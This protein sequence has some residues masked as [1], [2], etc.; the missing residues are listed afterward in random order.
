MSTTA[1]SFAGLF[2]DAALFPPGNADM[3][4]AVEA[5]LARRPTDVGAVV[6]TF[7]CPASRLDELAAH[8]PPG[9][10]IDVAVVS[11][12]ATSAVPDGIRVVAVESRDPA[13][14]IP[15][16]VARIVEVPWGAGGDLAPDVVA[17][18][19]TGGPDADAF[20]TPSELAGALQ[21]LVDRRAPFKLT[22]GLHRAVRAVD[23]SDG[24]LHHGFANVLLAVDALLR[25]GSAVDAELLL[26]RD[27]DGVGHELLALGD[28]RLAPVREIFRSIGTC[29]IDEPV[30]DLAAFGLAIA[31]PGVRA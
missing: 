25:D 2:D 30:D 8:V 9:V 5:H 13:L 12:S 14:A 6:A 16:G 20:P 29:S 23:P 24:L 17:K 4:S 31:G 15:A 27:D 28:D 7:V 18:L 19:R 1:A 10:G 11:D 22:A 21:V 3:A 26:A